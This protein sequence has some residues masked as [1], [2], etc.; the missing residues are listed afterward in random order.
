[1]R[2]GARPW[3]TVLANATPDFHIVS[4]VRRMDQE[5][6]KPLHDLGVPITSSVIDKYKWEAFWDAPLMVP[7]NGGWRLSKRASAG[8]QRRRSA[9]FASQG[10]RNSQRRCEVRDEELQ[11]EDERRAARGFVSRRPARHVRRASRLHRLRRREPDT[12]GNSRE[13]RSRF[14]RVPITTPVSSGLAIQPASRL[15]WHDV[16]GNRQEY[17]F[18]AAVNDKPATVAGCQSHR[19]R[20]GQ[21]RFGR[22]I[23]AAAQLLLV[24]RNRFNLGY[25][26]YRKDSDVL[27]FVRRPAGRSRGAPCVSG[28]GPTDTSRISRCGSARPG[29]WQRMPVYLYVSAE[30]GRPPWS[31]RSR[32]TRSDH[33]KPLPGYKV[34]ATHFHAGLA[35]AA[36]TGSLNDVLPDFEVVK[37]AGINI[38]APIDGWQQRHRRRRARRRSHQEPGALLPGRPIAF[39]QELRGH[40]E[41]RNHVR[42]GQEA[43]QEVGRAQRSADLPPD[44]LGARARGRP[45]ARR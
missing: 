40:A 45:A 22:G 37:A 11:R 30:P 10:G 38:F 34:M 2:R 28:R 17:G 42:R 7:G 23:P 21:G 13:D 20:R 24:A 31:R 15:V 4:G 6:L 16:A 12:P 43:R 8:G 41:R 36:R 14:S 9:G 39:R 44:L 33:Y 1:M 3:A 5:Q 27:V 19:G 29:T 26:W 32:I 25:D 18:A 35:T